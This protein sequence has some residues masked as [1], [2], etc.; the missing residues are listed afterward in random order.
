MQ[1]KYL[2]FVLT[3][4]VVVALAMSK[5]ATWFTNHDQKAIQEPL[6][7]VSP[8]PEY[9]K[10]SSLLLSEDL[11]TSYHEVGSALLAKV[12]ELGLSAFIL[13]NEEGNDPKAKPWFHNLPPKSQSKAARIKLINIPHDSVWVRDFGP[14]YARW[15]GKPS[16]SKLAFVDFIYRSDII[17]N[18]TVPYM[19]ALYLH[20]SL[21]SVPVILDG[22]SFLSN[23]ETCIVS[24]NSLNAK[25]LLKF[26]HVSGKPSISLFRNYLKHF[27]GCQD[28]LI[29]ADPAHEHVDMWAKI[30][31]QNTILVNEISEIAI[32]RAEKKYGQLNDE[33]FKIKEKLDDA[34]LS[35][36][37]YFNVIRIPMPIP[38]IEVFR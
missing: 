16:I 24:V 22:G 30:I 26:G 25:E 31:N 2:F 17:I 6:L 33:I 23:G 3:F 12:L 28:L 18:D 9:A 20:K 35:L 14:T 13:A 32:K 19:V 15:L 7:K 11:L 29:F 36:E 27:V 38:D 34:A 10:V 21:E 8:I 5:V 4:G 37:Q 1:I